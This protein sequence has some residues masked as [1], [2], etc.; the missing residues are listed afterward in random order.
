M[1]DFIIISQSDVVDYDQ[2]AQLPLDRLELYRDLVFP[3][4][5]RHAGRFRPHLDMMHLARSHPNDAGLN[6]WN[7]PTFAGIHLADVLAADGINVAVINNIRT[8]WTRFCFLYAQCSTPPLVGISTTFYLSARPIT[9]I[10]K[11]LRTIDPDMAIVLGGAFVNEQWRN[12]GPD[13]FSSL[14]LKHRLD[15]I[16]HGFNSEIDLRDLI[17]ARRGRGRLADVANL[18]YRCDDTTAVTSTCWHDPVLNDAPGQWDRLDLPF[19]NHTVQMRTSS[20]CPFACAFCSYPQTAQ[21]FFQMEP[22]RIAAHLQ[23]IAQIPGVNRIIFIDDTFN[24]PPRRF[25]QLLTLLEHHDFTWFAFIRAQ[26]VDD[27]IARRMYQSGCRGVYLG[28]ESA[29]DDVLRSMNK[30]ARR[31]EYIR[32]VAALKNA[33]IITLAAFII[34]FPGETENSLR[35]D[36]TFIETAGLDYYTL[37]EFYYMPHTPVHQHSADFGLSGSGADWSHATMDSARARQAKLDMF[38]EIKNCTWF[39]ADANLW[40]LAYLYDQGFSFEQIQRGQQI[41]NTIIADQIAGDLRDPHPAFDR[42]KALLQ[43]ETVSV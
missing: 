26:F 37:K 33:G 43:R 18:I 12:H 32:G 22:G 35:D 4:M 30:L 39:D 25:E 10:I 31:D 2:Y 15:Y 34:G 29:N 41:I 3:R 5:V 27:R 40:G 24:V 14:M 6:I 8:E 16:L 1:I 38:G 11:K 23:N 20:G 28:L 19:I 13:A 7:L 36:V 21:G 17:R 9:R 42:L